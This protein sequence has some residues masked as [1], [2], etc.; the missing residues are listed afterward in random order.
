MKRLIPYLEKH[1]VDC[2]EISGGTQYERCNKIIPCHGEEEFTNLKEARAIKAITAKP[3]ITLAKILD[4][5]FA[6]ELIQTK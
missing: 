4:A 1:G 6:K 5:Q 2:F 3:V